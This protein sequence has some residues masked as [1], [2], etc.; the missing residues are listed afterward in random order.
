MNI[1]GLVHVNINCRDY[2]K[3]RQFYEMLGFREVWAVPATN[4]AEVAAAVGMPPYK[5]KG[6]IMSL[7]DATPPVSIDLLEW[8]SPRDES[9]PYE[10][11]YRPGIARLALASTNIDAD[12][13]YLKSQGVEIL[14]PPA[15]V[16]MNE[17]AGSR[18]FCF[19]DPDG[20]FLELVQTFNRAR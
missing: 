12:Y 2:E 16:M 18:F 7:A 14:S 6:A 17:S 15:T 3:S 8:Q 10:N 13:A 20:T 4:T 5:V 11:L 19:M 9:P 1:R